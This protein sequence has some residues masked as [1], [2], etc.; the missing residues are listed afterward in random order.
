MRSALPF[1]I[2]VCRTLPAG[3]GASVF[4]G[5]RSRRR[6]RV[7][8]GRPGG[9]GGGTVPSLTCSSP[10]GTAALPAMGILEPKRT[11]RGAPDWGANTGLASWSC[12]FSPRLAS[13]A[14]ATALMGPAEDAF[15]RLRSFSPASPDGAFQARAGF[16]Y[17]LFPSLDSLRS[18]VSR[19]TEG[20]LRN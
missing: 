15:S 9:C 5:R 12:F 19:R 10:A 4:F 6:C 18:A 3:K 1:S 17:C 20:L 8:G 13:A 11:G 7:R 14:A 16:P 2:S